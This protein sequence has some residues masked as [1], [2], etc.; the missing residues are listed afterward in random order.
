M[1]DLAV[2][3]RVAKAEL[4]AQYESQY[5]RAMLAECEGNVSEAARMAGMDRVSVQRMIQ[6]HN[7]RDKAKE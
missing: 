5:I 1:V 2:P 3:L 4:V 7:L 6:R